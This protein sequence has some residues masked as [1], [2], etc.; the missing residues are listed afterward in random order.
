M[1]ER[2]NQFIDEFGLQLSVN[3]IAK[4]GD[5]KWP[6]GYQHYLCMITSRQPFHV[7]L[8]TEYSVGPGVATSADYRPTLANVLAALHNDVTGLT[9]NEMHFE[10]WA[11]D[12]GYDPDSRK[13]EATFNAIRAL[14]RQLRLLLG[15]TGYLAFLNVRVEE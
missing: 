15:E 6:E 2:L 4:R 3:P 7:G 10:A 12:L 5:T 11:R 13:A 9:A 8:V 14:D 1:Y